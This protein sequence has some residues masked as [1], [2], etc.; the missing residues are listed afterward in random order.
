[1]PDDRL[2]NVGGV[3]PLSQVDFPDGKLAL[4]YQKYDEAKAFLDSGQVDEA[5]ALFVDERCLLLDLYNRYYSTN[6]AAAN[7]SDPKEPPIDPASV[8]CQ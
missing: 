6:R 3:V 1:M 8:G 7:F 4:A 2:I 5:F